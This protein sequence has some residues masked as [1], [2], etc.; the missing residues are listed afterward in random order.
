MRPRLKAYPSGVYGEVARYRARAAAYAC[1]NVGSGTLVM[2]NTMTLQQHAAVIAHHS[3][4]VAA[5][6]VGAGVVQYN[7][8]DGSSGT[9]LHQPLQSS[10]DTLMRECS[11]TGAKCVLKD[12]TPQHF[13]T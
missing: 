1:Q 5:V 7:D 3:R 4:T 13:R 2:Y 11:S 8:M 12:A 6:V 10:L 9:S